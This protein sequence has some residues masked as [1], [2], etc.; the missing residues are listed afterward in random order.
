VVVALDSANRDEEQFKDP[1]VFYITREKSAHLAF[2]KGIHLCL[3]APR[4]LHKSEIAVSTLIN[5][6]PNMK[7]QKDVDTLEW[8]PGMVVRG[9]K[10]IPVLL[11]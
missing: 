8:R 10:E 2:G 11:K 3:G 1:D 5:R 7:L 9:V 6:F 4:A